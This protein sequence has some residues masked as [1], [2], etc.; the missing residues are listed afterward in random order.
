MAKVFADASGDDPRVRRYLALALGRIGDRRA[1]P[2]LLQ[3]VDDAGAAGA[4]SDPETQVY[5]VWALGVIGDP[6][7]VPRL[8]ALAAGDD[9]GLRKAA[10]HALGAFPTEEARAAL[11]TAL[12][13][14]VADVRWNAA[15]A[16]ARRRDP[17]AVPVLLAMMDR[18]E[19]ARGARPHRRAALGGDGA[20][21]DRGRGVQRSPRKGEIRSPGG[22]ASCARYAS[23]IPTSRSATR[24]PRRSRDANARRK[25]QHP[26]PPRS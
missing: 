13:D 3:A 2:A 5:A 6:Q 10:V 20:S 1:V 24:R 14:P 23:R 8:V 25:L 18:G 16:L 17:A 11:A 15:V 21:G 22:G 9:P 4:Q 7:A 26:T 19:L 12:S